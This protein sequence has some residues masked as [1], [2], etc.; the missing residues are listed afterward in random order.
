MTMI[1]GSCKKIGIRWMGS[2]GNLT[3]TECPHCGGK[4]CQE[5]VE[6][7]DRC[8]ECGSTDCNGECGGDD[9]MGASG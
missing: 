6:E 1:C 8:A 7:N 3:H 5:F 9:M 2:W 4:N